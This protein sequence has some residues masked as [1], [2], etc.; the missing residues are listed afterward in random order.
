MNERS[1]RKARL[2]FKRASRGCKALRELDERR[3]H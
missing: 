1:R 2:E 3:A